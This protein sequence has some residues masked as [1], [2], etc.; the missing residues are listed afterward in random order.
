MRIDILTIFPNM[1][2]GFLNES[3]LKRAQEKKLVEIFVHNI[4]DF[5][6]YK[7]KRVDDYPYGGGAGMVM[8]VE[9]IERCISWLTAS[10]KYDEIIYLTPD[11]E[12]FNQKKANQL[13]MLN[14]II[15]LCGH[16]KG[17]DQRVRDYLV[18]ME[19]SIGD[20]VLTGGELAAAVVTDAIVRLIPGVLHDETS[21]LNDSFQTGL[22]D[23]PVYTRPA[24]YKGWKVPEIL[25]SGDQKKIEAWRFEQ[26]LEKT[27]KRR[28]DLLKGTP[29]EEDY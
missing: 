13:S 28:P 24:E 23:S 22:L 15:L 6:T 29:Y 16:Y 7:H 10:R 1:F 25:F 20:Y 2:T 11:G 12:L 26:A 5:S 18:T 19:L 14:N 4:R 8:M 3:I 21:A 17:I 9:P 27:K